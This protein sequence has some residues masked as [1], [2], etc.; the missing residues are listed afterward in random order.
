MIITTPTEEHGGNYT[1]E[2]SKLTDALVNEL[3]ITR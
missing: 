1:A 2:H 3:Y